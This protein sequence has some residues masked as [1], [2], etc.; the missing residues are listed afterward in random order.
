MGLSGGTNAGSGRIAFPLR[1]PAMGPL[2]RERDR[3]PSNSEETSHRSVAVP[4]DTSRAFGSPL[5][6][7][8]ASF[9]RRPRNDARPRPKLVSTRFK[10]RR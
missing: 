10:R 8:D 7:G 3:L 2:H 4:G 9:A 6:I 1:A 5:A